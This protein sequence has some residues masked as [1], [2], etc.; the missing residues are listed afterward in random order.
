MGMEGRKYSMT[1]QYKFGYNTQEQTDEVNEIRGHYTALYWEYDPR[2]GRRWNLDPKPVTWESGYSVNRGN[3]IWISDPLGDF[4]N[5]E[6]QKERAQRKFDR[7]ITKPLKEMEKKGFTP[8]QIQDEADKLAVKYQ[9]TRWLHFTYGVDNPNNPAGKSYTSTGTGM[10]HQEIIGIKAY[11]TTSTNANIN[12]GR[13]ADGSMVTTGAA[14][15]INGNPLNAAVG[16]TVNVQFNPLAVP[17]S[18]NV[19][20]VDQSGA[21]SIIAT[22]GGMIA[23]PNNTPGLFMFNQTTA[24]TTTNAGQIQYTV[25]NSNTRV[26]M[27]TWQLQ[28][29]V[30]SPPTLN[31]IPIITSVYPFP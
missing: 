1:T 5:P 10:K 27:D 4:G 20:T 26:T 12:F 29:Q 2:T 13:P 23:D 28:L 7:K 24:I 6:K 30:I 18:L 16:S 22:T 8:A 15:D 9:N 11:Q 21:T 3:P 25:Q 17:N 14:T 19:T 31:P